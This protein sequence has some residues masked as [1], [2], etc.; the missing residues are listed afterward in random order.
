VVDFAYGQAGRLD[1]P[2][3]LL[4]RRFGDG[5]R[6][7]DERRLLVRLVG[8]GRLGIGKVEERERAPPSPMP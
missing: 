7:V 2:L 1:A 4:L 5:E 8:C 6:N 3:D